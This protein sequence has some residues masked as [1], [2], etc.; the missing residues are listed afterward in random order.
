MIRVAVC[1][2]EKPVREYLA[3]LI[4]KQ[5]RR[6]R[7]LEYSSASDCLA[8]ADVFDLLFLDI[9]MEASGCDMDGISL[10]K[11]I[12]G[13]PIEPQPLIVFV[14]GHEQYVFDAFDVNAFQY[15]LKPVDEQRFAEVFGRAAEHI[16]SRDE[17][18][19]KANPLVIQYANTS[20]AIPLDDLYYIESSN[21]KVVLHMKDEK[22]AYY[23][24]IGTLEEQL[25]GR[26]FRIHKGYLVNFTYVDAYNKTELTLVNGERLLISRYKYGA[27]IK[28]YLHFVKQRLDDE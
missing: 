6:C 9:G 5:G 4:R 26:F 22:C 12:R 2:D 7:V 15:L 25:Q 23:A 27:F 19:R 11:Q 1:D 8:E 17:R 10:A 28:A 20:R 24:K 16:L 21:H 18:M 13:L 14:T 3:A